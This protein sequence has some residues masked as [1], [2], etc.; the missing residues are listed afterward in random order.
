MKHLKDLIEKYFEKELEIEINGETEDLAI[1]D[2]DQIILDEIKW[3]KGMDGMT[4]QQINDYN[5]YEVCDYYKI[6]EYFLDDP[7]FEQ[8]VENKEWI[9]FAVLGMY[10]PHI[11]GYA[12]MNNGGMLLFNVE[13]DSN[14]PPIIFIVDGEFETIA[15]NFAK[16][17]FKEKK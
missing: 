13:A 17:K 8:K 2:W 4:E 3:E 16:L 6:L 14:N 5:N 12:E 9:P 7:E 15:E 1:I 11:Y 10:Q